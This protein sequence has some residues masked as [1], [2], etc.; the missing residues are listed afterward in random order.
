M[1]ANCIIAVD[2][3]RNIGRL[4]SAR[5]ADRIEAASPLWRIRAALSEMDVGFRIVGIRMCLEDA[6]VSPGRTARRARRS[7]SFE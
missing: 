5:V 1:M 4:S 3:E 6:A 2:S 7:R